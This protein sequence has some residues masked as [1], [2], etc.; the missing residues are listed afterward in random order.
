MDAFDRFW[1]WVDKPPES[2]LTIP[3]ELHRAVMELAPEDRR[4]RAAVEPRPQ[5]DH[6]IQSDDSAEDAGQFL[7]AT[8]LIIFSMQPIGQQP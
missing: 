7:P 6:G 4:D 5:R 1:Q 8:V 2:P 3:A